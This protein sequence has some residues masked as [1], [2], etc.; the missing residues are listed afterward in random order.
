MATYVDYDWWIGLSDAERAMYEAQ[1]QSA[2]GIVPI[3]KELALEPKP[4]PPA[5]APPAPA[6][7]PAPHGPAVPPGYG[8]EW[9]PGITSYLP[10][11]EQGTAPWMEEM[12]GP[13]AGYATRRG[14]FGRR[15]YNPAEQYRAAQFD[16]LS[17]LYEIQQGLSATYPGMKS[18]T[19]YLSEW[20]SQ[21]ENPW[22]MYSHARNLLGATRG[23]TPEEL[24]G[25]GLFYPGQGEQGRNLADLL[26][27]ALRQQ[28]GRY[29]A[30]GIAGRLPQMRERWMQQYPTAEGQVGSSFLNY[31]RSTF[32]F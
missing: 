32:G 7:A 11:P 8:E 12:Y 5:P 13:W 29:G 27:L 25:A 22:A 30:E 2:G 9:G 24:G 31:L 28:Y 20:S 23:L 19:P 4:A 16:P 1:A 10:P 3:H 17:R 14:L 18:G 6:P 26:R 21:Y 15:A